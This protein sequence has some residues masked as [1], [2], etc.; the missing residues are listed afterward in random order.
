MIRN[1]N[2]NK[3]K[4]LV[5]KKPVNVA[6][7]RLISSNNNSSSVSEVVNNKEVGA[8]STIT[9]GKLLS[10]SNVTDQDEKTDKSSPKENKE[11]KLSSH[12]INCPSR[13]KNFPS[14]NNSERKDDVLSVLYE[15]WKSANTKN[16]GVDFYQYEI[17]PY[18]YLST[19]TLSDKQ[20]LTDNKDNLQDVFNTDDEVIVEK[21]CQDLNN[22]WNT[23]KN[24]KNSKVALLFQV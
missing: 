17:S 8:E 18:L 4:S 24:S 23:L 11:S 16:L 15:H 2:K 6:I 20:K 14:Y 19:E 3:L 22:A 12:N 5:E 7:K 13:Y 21:H 1:I 10:S 9:D